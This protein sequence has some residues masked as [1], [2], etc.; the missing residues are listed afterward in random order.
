MRTIDRAVTFSTTGTTVKGREGE[1]L[2]DTAKRTRQHIGYFCNGR[3]ICKSCEIYAEESAEYISAP[4]RHETNWFSEKQ[5][6]AGHRLAYQSTTRSSVHLS[7]RADELRVKVWNVFS[8]HPVRALRELGQLLSDYSNRDTAGLKRIFGRGRTAVQ[9]RDRS[10][11][12]AYQPLSPS[13]PT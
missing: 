13:Q 7:T 6:E 3:G 4:T 8:I 9:A 5:I 2:L 12:A 1:A 10:E 11:T